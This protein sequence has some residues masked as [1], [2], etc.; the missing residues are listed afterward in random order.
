MAESGTVVELRVHGVSGTP[1]EALLSCPVEFLELQAGDKSAGFYRRQPWIDA[2]SGGGRSTWRRVTEAYSWGGLTSGPASRALW[3]LFLP[4]I[5]INLAHWMLPPA[6]RQRRAAAIAVALLRVIALSLTLTLMLAAAVAVMDVTVWQCVALDYCAAQWGPLAF[7][8]SM[9]RGTQVSLSAV[10]LVVVIVVLWRLG[11]ENAR[12]IGRPPDPAVM[13]DEVPLES[14]TF[15][16]TDPS[17]MRL[18]A[19]HVMAWTAGLAALTLAA[20]LSYQASAAGLTLLAANGAVLAIAVLATAWNRATARGGTGADRLTRPLL[21]L[22]WISLGLLIVSLVWVALSDSWAGVEYP[23]APTHF[24][25]LRGAI[26]VLLG[27]QVLLLIKLFVFTGWSLRGRTKSPDAAWRPTLRGFTAPFVALIAWLAGGAFSVG[28]GLWT[29]QVLGNAVVSTAAATAEIDRRTKIL[30]DESAIFAD[31][32]QRAGCRGSADRAAAVP[33]DGHG[34][35]RADRGD[36]HRRPG[37]VVVG[38]PAADEIRTARGARRLSRRNGYRC[39]GPTG[40]EI[41]RAGLTDR[42][43]RHPDRGCGLDGRGGDG[44]TRQVV[45]LG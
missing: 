34:R 22:R 7:L 15:W 42:H 21:L 5:F 35:R 43:G 26:Y 20:P 44:G 19:C 39:A 30:G 8:A 13:A 29:A 4:F 6:A 11:G 40:R 10:P 38:H 23:P 18:R 33:L 14:D 37:R 41:P 45:P 9:P 3:L 28:V 32:S 2:A 25:G 1:P 31:K 24:P 16:C 27:V 36:D 17:V 12:E